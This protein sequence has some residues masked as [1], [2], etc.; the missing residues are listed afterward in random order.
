VRIE[1][2]HTENLLMPNA[3]DERFEAIYPENKILHS[4]YLDVEEPKKTQLTDA[5]RLFEAFIFEVPAKTQQVT[6]PSEKLRS[7]LFGN[8]IIADG[9]HTILCP[10]NK[11]VTVLPMWNE[12][13]AKIIH[14]SATAGMLF[15]FFTSYVAENK[16]FEG[17]VLVS[18]SC[19]QLH[20]VLPVIWLANLKTDVWVPIKTSQDTG[21]N[22]WLLQAE[23]TLKD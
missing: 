12:V 5:M 18:C 20:E 19:G 3:V 16:S 2:L 1:D 14:D 4:V 23:E 17:A 11:T 10:P 9:D 15:D 13:T 21:R 8:Q 7:I 6:L 22:L